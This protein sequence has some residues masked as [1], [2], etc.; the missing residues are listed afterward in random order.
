MLNGFVAV[1]NSLG[2]R[3]KP[4]LPQ[5]CN[6]I[7]SCLSACF[8]VAKGRQQANNFYFTDCS[9]P[10]TKRET[11]ER[12]WCC[13]V[14]KIWQKNPLKSWDQYWK[15]WKQLLVLVMWQEWHLQSRSCFR[16]W[17]QLWRISMRIE[18]VQENCSECCLLADILW[19][20]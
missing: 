12:S 7:K 10:E 11:N 19:A 5:T 14:R 2:C 6:T 8:Y 1:V 18:K 9:S 3:V 17:P 13:L 20:A 4:Y 15:H 16:D